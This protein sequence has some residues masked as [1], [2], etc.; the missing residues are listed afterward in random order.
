MRVIS[1]GWG[2]Q[3]FTLAAMSALGEL[4][5][6]DAVIHA[7]TT[8]ER[9]HTYEFATR[10]VPWLEEH[11]TWLAVVRA[12]GADPADLRGGVAIPAYTATKRGG[13]LD[14]QCSYAWK[15][16]LVRRWLRSQRVRR[17]EMWIGISADEWWRAKPADVQWVTHRWP[18]LERRMTRQDC[19]TWLE[20]HSLEVPGKSSCTFCPMHSQRAWQ[21]MK[22]ENGPDWRQ[23]VEIDA[24]IRDK[25]PPYSLY[26]HRACKP[27]PEAVEIPEDSGVEQMDWLIACESGACFI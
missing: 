6:V 23:A 3:S 25:R 4:E 9:Q 22:R 18:L 24:L 19:I 13:R 15:T 16:R 27:L 11:D 20:R 26:L 14:R 2:I 5:P 7:D 8:Y 21:E 10:W 17:A 1:L 12:D